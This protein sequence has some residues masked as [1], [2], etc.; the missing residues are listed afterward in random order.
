MGQFERLLAYIKGMSR[1]TSEQGTWFENFMKHVFLTSPIYKEMYE[2]VWMWTEFPYNGGRHDYGIDLVAKARNIDEY[3]AIQC[4]FYDDEHSVSKSDVDTFLTASGKPFYIKGTPVRYAGRVIVSTTDKWSSTANDIIEGQIPA[5]SRIRLKDLKEIGIDWDS[6]SVDN[7]SSMKQS[8]KKVVRP[9]Q[10]TAIVDVLEGFKTADRGK[11]IMACGTGKTYT[12]LKIV[13]E[14]TKG[15]GNVLFLVPS[16][17]L[18]N[19]TLLEWTK[20]CNYD[21][22]VYAIC[23]D[24]KVTKSSKETVDNLAD[25]IVPATTNVESLVDGYTNLWNALGKKGIRFFFSTYQSIDV[26]SKF[27]KITG[28]EFDITICDEAH[29]TTGVTLAGDDESSFVKVHDNDIIHSKKRLY[30]TATPRIYGD[31]SKKKATC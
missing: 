8:K 24:P 19:Q 31:E 2:N 29:R 3:Y 11:L 22:Q 28:L 12:A 27:Q 1:N 18:L 21:Y 13:E 7:P 14:I 26:I 25:T 9:H 20:E 16:I 5:V 23:S 10:K 15:D 4:K 17:S 30:M 6:V